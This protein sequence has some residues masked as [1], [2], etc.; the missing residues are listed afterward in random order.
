MWQSVKCAVHLF[1]FSYFKPYVDV[2]SALQKIQKRYIQ[3]FY[4][5]TVAKRLKKAHEISMKFRKSIHEF[6]VKFGVLS[7]SPREI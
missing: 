4:C 5:F 6:S 2:K 7:K 1:S 3:L